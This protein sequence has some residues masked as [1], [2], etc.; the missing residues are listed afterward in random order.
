MKVVVTIATLDPEHGGPARTVPALCR[1]LVR[2]R[3]DLELVTVAD[4]GRSRAS[5]ET[6][7]FNSTIIETGATRYQPRAWFAPFKD[8]LSRAVYGR[9][10]AVIYDVGLWLPSNHFTTQIAVQ[11]RV[12]L[13]ISP[14][15]MLSRKALAVSKWKK[16]IKNIH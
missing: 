15:G 6:A 14:R 10:D 9:E 2:N 4:R 5:L 11:A 13:L 16:M 1:A 3:A 7:G 8:A 12:P